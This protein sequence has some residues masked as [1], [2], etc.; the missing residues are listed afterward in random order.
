MAAT[1]TYGSLLKRYTPE[2]LLENDFAKLS[3]IWANCDK[4][5]SWRGG[6]YEMPVLEAGFN[7]VQFGSLASSTDIGEMT[8]AMGT[9]TMKEL[10]GSILVRESDLYRH[11]D[12][13]QS[14]LKIMPDK[15]EEFLKFM[16]E[17]VSVGFL[18]GKRICKATAD[19]TAGGLITVDKPHL[20]RVGMKVTVDDDNSSTVNGYVTAININSGVLTIK[21]ARASGSAVDLSGYTVAQ[22]ALVQIVGTASENFTSL[23]SYLLDTSADAANGSD[24]AYGLT[25]ANYSVLQ[26]LQKDASGWSA[27]TILDDI[28]A[29]FYTFN[30]KRGNIFKEVWVSYGVFKNI[31]KNLELSK[32]AA[33]M[34]KKAGYGFQ[35]VDIVG[36]EGM[37]KIV[38]LREMPNDV[39][40]FGDV[41]KVKFAGAEPFKRKMY[42]GDEFFMVRGTD[43]PQY[44]SDMALRGDFIVKPNQWGVAYNV[45]SGVSA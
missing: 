39:V 45:A 2:S 12:P 31:S 34:D 15:I 17:Q 11:G 13:E 21:D 3:Y 8:V 29:S 40:Y 23:K 10:W 42:N 16:Q 36:S 14:Y 4:D 22:N 20:F 5:K 24:T 26:A 38:A 32:R 25:K 37:A 41:S 43:G 18:A 33:I 19:G 1:A 7:S 35:S 30:E 28:L 6:T 9:Q 44:I 27:D